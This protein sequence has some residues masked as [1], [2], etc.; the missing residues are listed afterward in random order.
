MD[1]TLVLLLS[2]ALLQ[3]E[4]VLLHRQSILG[5]VIAVEIAFAVAIELELPGCR[6]VSMVYTSLTSNNRSTYCWY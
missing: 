5:Y 2:F 1:S 6:I 4:V 3:P